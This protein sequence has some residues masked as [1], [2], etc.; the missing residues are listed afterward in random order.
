[1][2]LGLL[3][4]IA[5]N[6]NSQSQKIRVITEYWLEQNSFCPQCGGKLK[7]YEN[8]RPVADFYC[9]QCI[10]DYELKSK[11]NSLGNKITDGAYSTMI[12][13]VEDGSNTSFFFLTYDK[14]SW[15]VNDLMVVPSYFFTRDVIEER[16]P[17]AETAKRAGWVGCN[18]LYGMLP[19][20]GKIFYIRN[21]IP[22]SKSQVVD[23]W[24]KT[25][26]LKH[27]DD[28][29]KSWLLDVMYIV[30]KLGRQFTLSEIYFFE[31]YLKLRHPNN[32]NIKAKLRQQLQVLR[33]QNFLRFTARG[34][35]EVI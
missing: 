4:S 26:F 33:D 13:K 15:S 21:G 1:M 14:K 22:E 34:A 18:I 24:N 19:A 8:N 29:Q 17:L 9:K 30:G 12:D 2:N 25:V 32:N 27:S 5:D 3:N 7:Q 16:K 6:Y 23:S 20:D 10:L 35:Y 11:E 31:D 28:K